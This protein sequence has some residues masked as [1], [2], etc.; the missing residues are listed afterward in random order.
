MRIG[1]KRIL[2]PAR[3]ASINGLPFSYSSRANSTI[4]MA[5]LAASPISMTRPIWAKTLFTICRVAR[6]AKAPNTATGV[7]SKTLKG[8]DQLS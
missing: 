5:F 3:A 7:P 4:R 6:A 1:R 8:S 2:A